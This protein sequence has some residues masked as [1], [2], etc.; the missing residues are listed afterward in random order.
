MLLVMPVKLIDGETRPFIEQSLTA[1]RGRKV[2]FI[3]KETWKWVSVESPQEYSSSERRREHFGLSKHLL[4]SPVHSSLFSGLIR[5]KNILSFCCADS[6]RQHC[7]L[8]ICR[9]IGGIDKYCFSIRSQNPNNSYN[10]KTR[11]LV[12]SRWE[13]VF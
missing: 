6:S 1:K 2:R 4:A 9:Y 8:N 13:K 5:T 10:S 11:C 3:T 12:L 7:Y